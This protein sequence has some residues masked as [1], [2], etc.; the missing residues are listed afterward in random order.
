MQLEQTSVEELKHNSEKMNH[1]Y[2]P[3]T[4]TRGGTATTTLSALV[5]FFELIKTRAVPERNDSG[6]Q[7]N[8]GF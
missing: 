4:V 5:L 8:I 7:T 2:F 3:R 1:C 6:K